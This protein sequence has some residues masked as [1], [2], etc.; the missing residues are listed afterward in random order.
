[1]EEGAGEGATGNCE[2]LKCSFSEN[3]VLRGWGGAVE[4][5]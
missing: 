2:P 1:M 5:C 3:V 4:G